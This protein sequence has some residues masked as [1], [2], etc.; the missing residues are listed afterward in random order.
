M[1]VFVGKIDTDRG[2]ALILTRI[3]W[4]IRY[5][6]GWCNKGQS[7]DGGRGGIWPKGL[8]GKMLKREILYNVFKHMVKK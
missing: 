2:M 8:A 3:A 4:R 1:K 7:N 5:G 6:S